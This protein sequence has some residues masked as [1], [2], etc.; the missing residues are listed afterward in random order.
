MPYAVKSG[1][2]MSTPMVSG[3]IALLLEKNPAL[4]NLEVKKRLMETAKDLGY[5]HNLQGWGLFQL[6]HFLYDEKI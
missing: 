2:S 1:T 6:E 5:P 4:S 3:G